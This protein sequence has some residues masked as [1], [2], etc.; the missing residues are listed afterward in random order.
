[1]VH[2]VYKELMILGFI[3]FLFILAKDF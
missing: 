1:M 3:Q 2:K